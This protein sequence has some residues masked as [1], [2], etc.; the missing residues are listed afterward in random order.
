MVG[1]RGIEGSDGRART[2]GMVVNSHPLYPLSYV[3]IDPRG[4]WNMGW[5]TGL[6]PAFSCV[7]G[8]RRDHFD[9]IHQTGRY[10]QSPWAWVTLC[11]P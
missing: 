6:E 4:G 9:F 5:M 10:R 11:R 1:V 7:T 3:G 2:C 8:R